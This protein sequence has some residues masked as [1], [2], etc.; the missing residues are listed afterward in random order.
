MCTMNMIRKA[1]TECLRV[2]QPHF[3]FYVIRIHTL[4]TG[5]R[6][7]YEELYP[8]NLVRFFTADDQTVQLDKHQI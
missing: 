7:S 4:R 6:T 2:T 1:D 3:I 5:G 8:A